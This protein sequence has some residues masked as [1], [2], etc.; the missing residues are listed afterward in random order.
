MGEWKGGKVV[1][2]NIYEMFFVKL[3]SIGGRKVKERDTKLNSSFGNG[4]SP[5]NLSL[6]FN[7]TAVLNSNSCSL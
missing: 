6:E 4:V 1:E 7:T 2:H 3:T 5:L